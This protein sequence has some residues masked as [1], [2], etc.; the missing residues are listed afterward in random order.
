M[1]YEHEVTC[2]FFHGD[3]AGIMFFG[4]IF[5]FCH[6]AF[7][8]LIGEFF[9][10]MGASFESNNF[11]MPIVHCHADFK[12]PILMQDRLIVSVEVANLSDKSVTFEYQLTGKAD[13]Q[14]RAT[15]SIKHA[16]VDLK[17]FSSRTPPDIFVN[18]LVNLGLVER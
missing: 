12:R 11:G 5:E 16:F 17:K 4:R 18:G 9:P 7:E 8:E 10:H 14:L 13:G 6:E 3:R 2:R 1:A 15:A